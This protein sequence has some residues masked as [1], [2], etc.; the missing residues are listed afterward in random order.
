MRVKLLFPVTVF[1]LTKML[2]SRS[3]MLPYALGILAS[4]LKNNDVFVDLQDLD[5]FHFEQ[6]KLVKRLLK[7]TCSQLHAGRY[8]G[9]SDKRND[10]LAGSLLD[11]IE[12]K[13][14]DL[15]GISIH[16]G[17]QVLTSLLLAEKIKREY[18]IPIVIG[19]PYVTVFSHLF[20]EQYDFIDYA[21]VGQGEVPLLRL[22]EHMQGKVSLD[23]V[24]SLLYRDKNR[25]LFNGRTFYDVENQSCPDFD[26]LSLELYQRCVTIK[27]KAAPIPYSTSK[28]C[29]GKCTFC[30][31]PQIG[32][33]WQCKSVKK[34]VDDI[35]AL[36]QKYKSRFFSFKD[37]NFNTDANH[38]NELCDELIRR[39]A[40]IQWD[41]MVKGNNFDQDLLCKM[42]KAGCYHLIWG[43]ESGS[44]AT[45]ARMRKNTDA[46]EYAKILKMSKSAGISNTIF[47]M[48]NYPNENPYD[49]KQTA[50]FVKENE[51]FIDNLN[52]FVFA[53]FYGSFAYNNQEVLRIR[54]KEIALSPFYFW[55]DFE[56]TGETI[57]R[58]QRK[59]LVRSKAMLSWYSLLYIKH[60]YFKFPF[61]IML[62]CLGPKIA[63][64]LWKVGKY[65]NM[66]ILQLIYKK[67]TASSAK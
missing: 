4:Y 36:K 40:N 39:E 14:Y 64:Y 20:F 54:V 26:G 58:H 5:T 32:G 55:Y 33:P 42:K 11:L 19:G 34:V 50:L 13:N 28:G 8:T 23:K 59:E 61:N 21:I 46:K 63:R 57:S 56:P 1:S 66:D 22:T 62:K 53:I 60:R 30:I 48:L 31:H 15:I 37:S 43:I 24:P 47:I 45:L 27:E 10:L 67:D 35:A 41:A 52:F 65:V 44:N 3:F 16:S 25:A 12:V 51:K 6:K 49:I 38:I 7:H 2:D 29:L 9:I 18:N 17:A